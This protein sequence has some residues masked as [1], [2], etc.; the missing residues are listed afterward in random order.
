MELERRC[1]FVFVCLFH[2]F[3]FAF[4]LLLHSITKLITKLIAVCN[5]FTCNLSV[6]VA[7]SLTIAFFSRIYLLLLILFDRFHST[8]FI[9]S[10]PL[11][12]FL[13]FFLS[14]L[15][16][17]PEIVSVGSYEAG[18]RLDSLLPLLFFVYLSLSTECIRLY[19][20]LALLFFIS[21]SLCCLL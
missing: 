16:S 14:I 21:V 8:I 17:L 12:F 4:H 18:Y 3:S 2:S 11:L 1:R 6:A 13:S 10:S 9:A 20:L 7:S 15:L 5:V 19:S